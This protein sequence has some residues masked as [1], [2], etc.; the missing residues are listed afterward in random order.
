LQIGLDGERLPV[1]GNGF[2]AA[3]ERRQDVRP[4]VVRERVVRIE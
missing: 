1:F 3:A 4:R 2:L